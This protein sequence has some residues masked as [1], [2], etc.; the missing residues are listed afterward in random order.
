[1]D[2]YMEV[3]WSRWEES[4]ERKEEERRSEY[5]LGGRRGSNPEIADQRA[6]FQW[7]LSQHTLLSPSEWIK[8]KGPKSSIRKA[9]IFSNS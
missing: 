7:G 8:S 2:S 3:I 4:E 1:M 9:A 6:V 5:P